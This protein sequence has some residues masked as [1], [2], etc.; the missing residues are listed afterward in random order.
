MLGRISTP[1]VKAIG[2]CKRLV[3][4]LMEKPTVSLT[5]RMMFTHAKD[6]SYLMLFRSE[7]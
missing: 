7:R 1:T 6:D 4:L 3:E 5:P 2:R